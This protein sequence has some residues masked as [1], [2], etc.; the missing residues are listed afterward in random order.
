MKYIF[1]TEIATKVGMNAAVIYENLVY[2]V[3]KNEA[4][5]KHFHDG[6]YWTYSSIKGFITLFPFLTEKQIRTA[7]DKLEESGLIKSGNYNETT[8]DRT[9]W[10]ALL[11]LNNHSPHRAN[12]DDQKGQKHSPHRA[13]G[14]APQGKPIPYSKE[15][16]KPIEKESGESSPATLFPEIE[17]IEKADKTKKTLFANS[18]YKCFDTFEAKFKNPEYESVDLFYYYTSVKN[19]SDKTD[20]KRTARGWIATAQDFMRGDIEKKKLKI[21][22]EFQN[23]SQQQGSDSMM[24]YLNSMQ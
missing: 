5:E 21:K 19:W 4:N 6:Y 2:W 3:K 12:G 15:D 13:N 14:F 18:I 17:V 20:T 1:D 24:E 7:I 8:Y 16:S 9:K 23:S 10:Y 11:P 22:P